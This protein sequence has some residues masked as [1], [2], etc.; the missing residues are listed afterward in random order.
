VDYSVWGIA[1]DGT[2]TKFQKLTSWNVW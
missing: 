1:A 2:V